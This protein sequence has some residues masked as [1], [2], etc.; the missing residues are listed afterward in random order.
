MHTHSHRKVPLLLVKANTVGPL[1]STLATSKF[2][3]PASIR[4]MIDI[5][6]TARHPLE[7]LL[8]RLA[9]GRPDM[10]TLAVGKVCGTGI[11]YDVTC[12]VM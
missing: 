3:G 10:L 12:D 9:P 6:A 8:P 1:L 2:S 7:W 11:T 4:A 5:T